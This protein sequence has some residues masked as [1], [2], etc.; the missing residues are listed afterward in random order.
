MQRQSSKRPS[1]NK[2]ATTWIYCSVNSI[3]RGFGFRI[4]SATPCADA[5]VVLNEVPVFVDHPRRQQAS[6]V[7]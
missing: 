7:M 1:G 2:V 3:E 4:A 5:S 6:R